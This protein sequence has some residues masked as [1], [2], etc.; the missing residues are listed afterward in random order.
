MLGAAGAEDVLLS[1]APRC[2]EVPAIEEVAAFV[3]DA[4]TESEAYVAAVQRAQQELLTLESDGTR[5]LTEKL[6]DRLVPG[7]LTVHRSAF[8]T[9]SALRVFGAE[10]EVLVREADR[11]VHRV[12]DALHTIRLQSGIIADIAA[13]AGVP[14][15]YR[16]DEGAPGVMPEPQLGPAGAGLTA[17]E[18]EAAV[19]AVRSRFDTEWLV[20]ASLWHGALR[21]IDS[22]R[23]T[24]VAVHRDRVQAE[25]RLQQALGRTSLGHLLTVVGGAEGSR[26][27]ALA[28]ALVGEVRG[29]RVDTPQLAEQHPLLRSLLGS[30]QGSHA[31]SSPPDPTRVAEAWQRLS[32]DERERLITEVPAVIGNLPGVPYEARDE[33]NRR[34]LEYWIV[35]RQELSPRSRSAL[36]AAFAV[37]A[38]GHAG[39]PVRVVALRLSDATPLL[40]LGY[41]EPDRADHLTWEV[42]GMRNDAHQGLSGWD[43]ASRNLMAEQQRVLSQSGRSSE[44]SAVIVFMEADT[45]DVDRVLLPHAARTGAARLAAELDGAHAVR[46]VEAPSGS[47]AVVAHSY[48]TTT[49][50][51]A[52]LRTEHPV[53]SFTMLGSAGL[54]AGTVS[55]LGELGVDRD[56]R[57]APRIYTTM[58]SADALAPFGSNA[59]QRMQPNADAATLP[60]L[61]IAG[62]QSFSSEGVGDLR[63]TGGHSIIRDD[64]LGYLDRETQSLRSAAAISSELWDRVPGGFVDHAD[65]PDSRKNRVPAALEVR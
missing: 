54:D 6:S 29:Q 62:A 30:E 24:W 10:L 1:A 59:A 13:R 48:G 3:R 37:I 42:P 64:G 46:I 28:A 36:D 9:D 47:V 21:E 7:A 45:P 22:A 32:A 40:A 17:V 55:D 39:E 8:E 51:N 53:R 33:A 11:T 58:A 60:G 61:T 65:P 56:A 34:L 41:G 43:T 20:A 35:H 50:A 44:T 16:W 23:S 63:G 4:V 38:E 18:T 19:Q 57:G 12:E 26:P 14:G 27:D 49:A 15:E 31:W 52:L 5:S 2:V 25:T